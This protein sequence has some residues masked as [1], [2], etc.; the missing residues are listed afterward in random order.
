MVIDRVV[1]AKPP[2]S[3][4]RIVD[5]FAGVLKQQYRVKAVEG[6]RYGGEWCKEPFRK[7]GIAYEPCKL[8]K[9]DLYVNFLPLLTS[10]L[11]ELVDQ[12]RLISQIAGLERRTARSGK[13]SIDHAPGG[14]DDL[15]N[16]VAGVC[17][18]LSKKT[19]YDL[20]RWFDDD[21]VD[22]LREEQLA[23]NRF[24]VTGGGLS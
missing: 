18:M 6:D 4:A 16:V 24:V 14:H 11:V 9:S 17:G 10:G 8:A 3:P 23:F 12:P 13:D 2:F 7:A 15:A 5:Q 1:E 22:L 20:T 21:E 19:D